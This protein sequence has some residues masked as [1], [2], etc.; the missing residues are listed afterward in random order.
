[1]VVAVS[2]H[3]VGQHLGVAR[4]G[5]RPRNRMAVPVT[6]RGHRVHREDQIAGRHQRSH[7]QAPVGLDADRH[8]AR[9]LHMAANQ[10]METGDALHPLG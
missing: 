5:L 7:E 10:V 2:A 8:L 1:M 6:R 4:I 9:I 3:H